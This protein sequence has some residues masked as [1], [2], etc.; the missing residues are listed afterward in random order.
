MFLK[1]ELRMI[2][3]KHMVPMVDQMPEEFGR[4]VL[5]FLD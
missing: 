2:A 4:I 3:R 5:E 1:K